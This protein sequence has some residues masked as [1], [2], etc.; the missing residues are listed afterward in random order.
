MKIA[1]FCKHRIHRNCDKEYKD[2]HDYRPY[3]QKDFAHRCCYCNLHEDTIGVLSFQIDHFIP[4]KEFEGKRDELKT[5]YDNLMF[6]CPK[7]NRAKSNQYEG[8]ITTPEIENRLFYNP[9]LVDYNL[10]FYRDELGGIASDDPKGRAM[11]NQLKLY[12]P[13]HNYAW[14]LEKYDDLIKRLDKKI[15]TV[16]GESKQRLVEMQGQL[17]KDYYK[18]LKQFIVA[19][20]GGKFG[21]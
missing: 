13:I 4:R 20:R 11:I 3:L 6:T 16:T 17:Y 14:I 12:R 15:E 19:Y 9:D 2:Y 7:C 5:Q 8:D 10:I 1:D 18:K 21:S